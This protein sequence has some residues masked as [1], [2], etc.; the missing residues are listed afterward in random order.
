MDRLDCDRVFVAVL[1]LGSFAAAAARLGVKAGVETG[2]A[3][4]RATG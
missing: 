2:A 1:E 4:R 3:A